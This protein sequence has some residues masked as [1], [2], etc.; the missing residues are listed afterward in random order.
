MALGMTTSLLPLFV[1]QVVGGTV[2]DVG[3]VTALSGLV[4][5]PGSIFWG[6]LSCKMHRRRPFLLLGFA[7]FAASTL[8]LG[9][10]QDLGQVLLISAGGHC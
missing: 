5:V 7:G 2:A 1:V 10:G 4:G 6:N 8:L 3:Y 9:L